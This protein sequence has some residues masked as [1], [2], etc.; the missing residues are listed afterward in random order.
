MLH[1]RGGNIEIYQ[2]ESSPNLR[3]L[4][5]I[6]TDEG[7][8]ITD[9]PNKLLQASITNHRRLRQENI[10]DIEGLGFRDIVI[11]P[12]EVILETNGKMFRRK[13]RNIKFPLPDA[14]AD[15]D[16]EFRDVESDLKLEYIGASDVK[17]GVKWTLI[18]R[19]ETRPPE[20]PDDSTESSG[21]LSHP[22]PGLSPIKHNPNRPEE[23]RERRK[24]RRH[25]EKAL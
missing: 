10:D 12:D 3:E 9:N 5:L 14:A 8:G 15:V 21:L 25:A 23:L 18:W 19:D 11:Y 22:D 16:A 20:I 6:A 1:G 17:Q 24:S 7:P 4:K 2:T 13:G